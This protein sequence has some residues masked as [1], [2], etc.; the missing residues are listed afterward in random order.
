MCIRDRWVRRKPHLRY[1]PYAHRASLE[2]LSAPE[3]A[4]ISSCYKE[5]G[6]GHMDIRWSSNF[7]EGAVQ[8]IGEQC[9]SNFKCPELR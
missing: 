9:S 6:A 2:V 1:M 3:L 8:I 7:F 5:P 4:R